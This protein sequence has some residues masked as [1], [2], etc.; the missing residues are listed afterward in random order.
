MRI[1]ERIVALF[2]AVTIV[3]GTCACSKVDD[4]AL[5]VCGQYVTAVASGDVAQVM[6]L[7]DLTEEDA[8]FYFPEN[9]KSALV[10]TI[11][12]GSTYVIDEEKSIARTKDG[13]GKFICTFS[14]PDY[15]ACDAA[16]PDSVDAFNTALVTSAKKDVQIEIGLKYEEGAWKVADSKGVLE[17]LLVPLYEP[18]YEFAQDSGFL[19]SEIVLESVS[20]SAHGNISDEITDAKEIVLDITLTDDGE[21]MYDDLDL[22]YVFTNSNGDSI[23][24]EPNHIGSNIA[25]VKITVQDF[26]DNASYFPQ[27]TYTLD[28]YRGDKVIWTDTF[29][30][31]LTE[32][33]F[34]STS[35]VNHIYWQHADSSGSYFNTKQIE[36]KILLN[37]AYL[38]SGRDYDVTYNMSY[39][40]EY[41]IKDAHLDI[42]AEGYACFYSSDEYLPT[43]TYVMEVYNNGVLAG[44]A[45]VYVIFNL[46][47]DR[48]H[49][50]EVATNVIDSEDGDLVIYSGSTGAMDTIKDY[51][52]VDFTKKVLNLNTFRDELDASLASGENA[53]D[54]FV[55]DISYASYYALSD[56]TVSLNSIGIDYDE[57][58]YMYEYTLAMGM[59]SEGVIK[60]VT[61]E[62]NPGA[63]FY[64]RTVANTVFGVSEPDDIQPYFSNWDTFL[65]TARYIHDETN[66]NT[67]IVCDVADIETPYIMSRQDAWINNDEIVMNE[68]MEDFFGLSRALYD[69]DLT[70]GS[71]RWSSEWTGRISNKSVLSF[72][73][74]LDFGELFLSNSY[75]NWG[76]VRAPE[77]YYDGGYY[78]FVTKYCDMDASA[79]RLIRDISI[80]PNNLEAMAADGYSVNNLNI[81]MACSDDESYSCKWLDGQNP[82]TIFTGAAWSLNGRAISVYD[83]DINGCFSSAVRGYVKGDYSS[84]NIAKNHFINEAEALVK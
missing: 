13:T 28:L 62:I 53:P 16:N 20:G 75:S 48:Y 64:N 45:S 83:S 6:A 52:N 3:A 38:E 51:T 36:A 17:K 73:G 26:V 12:A 1:K 82:Y 18:P 59:D 79:A 14:I 39:N 33:T 68:Y 37:E 34:P 81:M 80:N 55:C 31:Y 69:E 41:L 84:V 9:Y 30:M 25:D 77:D 60:G 47:P 32:Y 10:S 78:I 61:W 23:S 71:A 46:D 5:D 49:E 72:F 7:S 29:S 22:T 58:K 8:K 11:L 19:F 70:F 67:R 24:G 65:S 43:G 50:E 44:A 54:M 56:K 35:I 66:G 27:S 57:F 40:D 4:A 63:V 42:E 21:E 2:L 76:V 74:T 15:I